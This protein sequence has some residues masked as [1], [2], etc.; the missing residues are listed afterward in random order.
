M[1]NSK[2]TSRRDFLKTAGAAGAVAAFGSPLPLSAEGT[3]GDDI[4]VLFLMTDQHNHMCLRAAGNPLIHTPNL[5]RLA[6]EGVMFTHTYCPT[7]FCSPTR[8]SIIT[9]LYPH[10]HGLNRNTHGPEH[11]LRENRFP[12]TEGILH[13]AGYATAHCGKWHVGD[14]GDLACYESDGYPG[15]GFHEYMN[16]HCPKENFATEEGDAELW[17]RPVA[18]TPAVQEAHKKYVVWERRS[19]QD[20]AV[21]GRTKI[22][23]ECYPE[24]NITRLTLNEIERQKDGPW[25]ITCSWSPPHAEWVCPDPYYSMYDPAGVPLPDNLDNCPPW[26][27]ENVGK[28]LGTMLEPEGIREYIRCYYGQV[29]YIDHFVGQILDKLEELGLAE[30]TLVIFTSDHGDMQGGH[31]I[32]GKSI[33]GFYENIA[34]VPFLM[35]MPGKIEPGTVIDTRVSLVDMMPTILDYAGKAAPENINGRSLRPLIEGERKEDGLTFCERT[36]PENRWIMRMVRDDRWKYT[37]RSAGGGNELYDLENDPEENENRYGEPT[38]EPVV[39]R[40]HEALRQWMEETGDPN[41]G[42]LS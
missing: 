28:K 4:N 23:L 29:S 3:T 32:V 1:S 2:L 7:P 8:A 38:L 31:G 9:G 17:G 37:Y 26:Y 36:S 39:K 18:M 35:R 30:K 21:I 10:R 25:M 42:L 24:A 22:P 33:A 41:V 13:D 19:K 40:L 6:A 16:E 12:T 14:K 11:W 15:P 5:D 27:E 34:R 20:I